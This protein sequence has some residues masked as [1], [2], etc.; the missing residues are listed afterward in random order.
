MQCSKCEYTTTRFHSLEVHMYDKHQGLINREMVKCSLCPKSFPIPS[1]IQVHMRRHTWAKPFK[2]AVCNI[3]LSLKVN[4][5][6]YI[7][8]HNS[9]IDKPFNCNLCILSFQSKSHLE[10]HKLRIHDGMWHKCDICENKY[11]EKQKLW[12]HK[13]ATHSKPKIVIELKCEL[14]SYKTV[15]AHRLK[16]HK[17]VKHEG[18]LVWNES[19]MFPCPQEGCDYQAKKRL[20]QSVW[21]GIPK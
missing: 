2:C 8:T 20:M 13:E 18:D 19:S 21:K 14:C 6:R 12:A 1:L 9:V 10:R 7:K 17:K 15:E 4:V 11:F 3:S 5:R 16:L